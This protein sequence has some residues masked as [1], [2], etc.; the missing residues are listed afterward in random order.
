VIDTVA[1]DAGPGTAPTASVRLRSLNLDTF[2]G[3]TAVESPSLADSSLV[4]AAL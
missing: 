4:P 1:T 3:T 2:T